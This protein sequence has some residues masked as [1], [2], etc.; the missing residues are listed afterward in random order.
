LVGFNRR[1]S[2]LIRE[3]QRRFGA[4]PMSIIYR[5]NAGA[6]AKDSWYQD[7]EL[8][9]GRI[10]GEVCHFIDTMVFLTGALP[11]RVHAFAMRDPD[12]LFDT[13]T[14][15]LLFDNGSVGSVCY[16][17]NGPKSMR[18]EYI[19]VFKDGQCAAIEDF[20]KLTFHT[21][22]GAQRRR[23]ISQDKGQRAMVGEFIEAVRRGGASPIPYAELA[24][25]TEATQCILESLRECRSVALGERSQAAM[26]VVPRP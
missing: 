20:R 13:V 2:P 23:L 16:F 17:A 9:G 26:S 25:V 5:I 18:K 3:V 21:A 7:R 11:T 1:F 6:I 12:N 10:V 22:R 19:E 14:I 15:N 8:G 4:A 24:A